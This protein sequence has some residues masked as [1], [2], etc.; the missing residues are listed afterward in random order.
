MSDTV[1][2]SLWTA[3]ASVVV[4]LV[5]LWRQRHSNLETS[6]L[7]RLKMVEERKKLA[8]PH[9]AASESVSLLTESLDADI[10]KLIKGTAPGPEIIG[11]WGM[12]AFTAGLLISAGPLPGFWPRIVSALGLVLI[13][14]GVVGAVTGALTIIVK[15]FGWICN[16][17]RSR[18]GVTQNSGS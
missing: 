10:R 9:E 2:A 4:V 6:I 15:F 5:Q 3:A 12:I 13:L 18:N 17:R 1:V 11:V 16:R 14:L 8:S 7:N